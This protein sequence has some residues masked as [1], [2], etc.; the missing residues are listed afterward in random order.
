MRYRIFASLALALSAA[1][2]AIAQSGNASAPA[3]RDSQPPRFRTEANFVRVDVYPTQAGRPVQD[4]RAEDFE[5]FEDGAPQSVQTFEHVVI[6]PAGPQDQRSEPSSIGE[7]QQLAANPRN[8][9]VVLFLDTPNVSLEGTWNVREPLVKL[10]DRLLGPDDLIGV[11]TPRMS[12]ADVVLA[13]KT[14]VLA[15]GLMSI[16]PWGERFTEQRDERERMY[17]ACYPPLGAGIESRTTAVMIARRRER[18]TLDALSEL[19]NYMRDIRQERKAILTVTEGWLLYGPDPSLTDLEKGATGAPEP[20]PAPDPISVGPDGKLT[21]KSTRTSTGNISRTDCYADRM[22]LAMMDDQQYFRDLVNDANHGNSTFYTVDPR[23]LAAFDSPMGAGQNAPPPVAVDAANLR[24]RLD[25]IRTLADATDGIAVVNSNNLDAGLKRVSDDLSS[26]Y[27]LGYYS[28][29]ATLD[30]KFHSIKVTVKRPGVEVRAR[31]GY[32]AATAGEVSAAKRAAA[33]PLAD[34]VVAVNTAIT[35]LAR[36][37]PDTRFS[38]NAVP[39]RAGASASVTTVWVAGEL[40]AIPGSDPWGSGGTATISVGSAGKSTVARVSLAPGQ[41]SFALPV[42]LTTPV[43]AGSLDVRVRLTGLDPAAE[44]LTGNLAIDPAAGSAQPMLFRRGPST[45]NRLAPAA[46]F[47][48]SRTERAR[49]EFAV[50]A[51]VTPSAA[52][53]LDKTGQPLAIPVAVAERIDDQTGQRWITA[54]ITLAALAAGDY[55]IELTVSG[56][57]GEHRMLTAIRVGR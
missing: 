44:E 30:G 1:A 35:G 16:W 8:R 28:T 53:L 6:S 27:L 18:V 48:F 52:R 47:Q 7:S 22:H 46:S 39:L 17:D 23:G 41:R 29:K 33:A 34:G 12:A 55:A 50:D 20:I 31:R 24:A 15:D 54:D 56:S 5:V 13:R 32:R 11:M 40:V 38:L 36:L 3:Q 9:V 49:L 37:R 10:L 19:V 26:Y 25:S 2:I 51:T 57:P 43:N 42:T 45:G 4:L 21:T 14:Q